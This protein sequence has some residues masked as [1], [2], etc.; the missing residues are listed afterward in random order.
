MGPWSSHPGWT[1][2]HG[3][4]LDPAVQAQFPGLVDV[5]FLDTSHEYD[6]TL[7][8]LAAWMP[9]VRPGGTALFHDTKLYDWPGYGWHGDVPPV[10]QALDDYCAET[11]LSW[12]ESEIDGEMG[13]G[14]IEVGNGQPA[15]S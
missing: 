2:I 15:A 12:R 8:E 1:F 14:I 6:L 9:R 10:H 5:F 4:D 3:D 11:G 13:L 7:K